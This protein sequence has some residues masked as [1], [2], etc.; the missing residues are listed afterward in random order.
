MAAEVGPM[1]EYLFFLF[2]FV[3]VKEGVERKVMG[4][5]HGRAFETM[6]R[7]YHYDEE[8]PN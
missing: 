4:P 5:A 2:P 3:L 8:G 7:R 1:H 6:T